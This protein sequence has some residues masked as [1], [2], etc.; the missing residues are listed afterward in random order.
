MVLLACGGGSG[1]DSGGDRSGNG[2]IPAAPT[3]SANNDSATTQEEVHVEI[4]VTNNDINVSQSSVRLADLPQNGNASVING[5][6]NYQPDD[7]FFGT[8]F[9]TYEVDTTTGETL[10]ATVNISVSNINDAPIARADSISTLINTPVTINLKSNDADDDGDI[11]QAEVEILSP[12]IL[13]EIELMD[14]SVTYLPSINTTG[15][16]T[17][18]YR[19][20][21]TAGEFSNTTTLS[22]Q[23]LP[24][25]ATTLSVIELEFP[26]SGYSTVFSNEFADMIAE[27]SLGSFD[28]PPNTLSFALYLEGN[29]VT[30]S[31]NDFIVSDL[32]TPSG[33]SQ[34]P[35]FQNVEFCDIQL[36]S[37]LIPRAPRQIAEVGTWQYRIASLNNNLNF[38][39]VLPSVKVSVR[40]GPT[41]K[42]ANSKVSEIAIKPIVTS[43]SVPTADIDAIIAKA[44]EIFIQ[45]GITA[46]FDAVGQISDPQ[47]SEVS[48]NFLHA[49]T[50]ALVSQGDPA[51]VNIFL[52]ESFAG[53][54]GAGLLGISGS[55]PAPMGFASNF[56]AVLVN[57]TATRDGDRDFHINSTAAV[58]VHEIGHYLG[59]AHTTEDRF[60]AYDY[61]DDT[62]Q[63]LEG[64]HDINLDGIA[65]QSECPDGAN[66]MFWMDE[67]I[68]VKDTFSQDQQTVI[69][70]APIGVPAI[71]SDEG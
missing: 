66:I 49:T 54:D 41:P 29:G 10:T 71:G 22:V 43:D 69:H 48:S 26:T 40:T 13:G 28:V 35:L 42:F 46:N 67:F 44:A 58:L 36:C 53:V 38:P 9:L 63:C 12:L 56:N 33:I 37:L 30:E 52:L 27:S 57:A 60:Q 70:L 61:V 6:I 45:N 47:F 15:N 55:I 31:P 51:K 4:S 24:I 2:N 14:N 18:T 16:E 21:D 32:I 11:I 5:V 39:S 17:I 64:A 1:G 50:R 3:S 20:L 68:F 7:N 34:A 19:L 65:N 8:D 59:L 23:I 25:T 62:P